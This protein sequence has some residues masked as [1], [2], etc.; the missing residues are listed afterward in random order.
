[1]NQ[2]IK[3][4]P[5]QDILDYIDHFPVPVIN[6][7]TDPP[8]YHFKMPEW[9]Q[10]GNWQEKGFK[11]IKGQTDWDVVLTYLNRHRSVENSYLAYCA[12]I[13]KLILYLLVNK[14]MIS[15][16]IRED[17]ES[18]YTFL[19]HPEPSKYWVGDRHRKFDMKSS[20]STNKFI[21][22]NWRPFVG[23]YN[24]SVAQYKKLVKEAPP[25][26]QIPQ[27]RLLDW[28]MGEKSI[29]DISVKI[30]T[31]FRDL[32]DG[33]HLKTIPVTPK[34][35][36][37]SLAKTQLNLIEHFL[38]KKLVH[39]V[40]RIINDQINTL[41]KY[42]P[43]RTGDIFSLVRDRFIIKMFFTTG[44]RI[45]ELSEAKVGSITDLNNRWVLNV[46]GKGDKP[47]PITLFKDSINAINEFR[48]ELKYKS[49]LLPDKKK[50]GDNINSYSGAIRSSKEL[51]WALVPQR[52]LVSHICRRRIDQ[53]IKPHFQRLADEYKLNS[54]DNSY[55]DFRRQKFEADATRLEMASAHWLRHSHG[56]YFAMECG[57]DMKAIME[58][59][60]HS[61]ADTT[62][63][64]L[65]VVD[66]WFGE[67]KKTDYSVS[68]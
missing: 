4:D 54:E 47:R 36:R 65:H 18:F 20:D 24:Y 40:I 45:N 48:G 56:T 26:T 58:R 5:N 33:G 38:E 66:K 61:K 16:M 43:E 1:M 15:E 13:E 57:R 37:S 7:E 44:L 41:R 10:G 59:M 11:T 23:T 32:F 28:G 2:Q 55:S 60:G 67:G 17:F 35:V 52:D 6:H 9:N 34:K 27:R 49:P 25:G 3:T 12:A 51:N 30:G 50:A 19:A 31:M 63:I 46:V 29:V 8:S 21:N 39:D 62:M 68:Y 14:K 22:P 53:L 64:Y 42:N